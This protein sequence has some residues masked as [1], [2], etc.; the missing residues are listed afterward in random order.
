MKTDQPQPPIPDRGISR[1]TT[2]SI[3]PAEKTSIAC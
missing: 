1:M 3:C 2:L